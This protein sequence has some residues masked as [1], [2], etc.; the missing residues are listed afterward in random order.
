L[1]VNLIGKDVIELAGVCPL[2][3]AELLF[4]YL[5]ERGSPVVD[6]RNCERAHTAVIQILLSSKCPLTGPPAG[7]FLKD[8]VEAVLLRR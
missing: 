7:T 8:H 2:E 5:L 1:T 3:D 6:W 4:Q